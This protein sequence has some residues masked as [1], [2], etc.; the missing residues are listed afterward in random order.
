MFPSPQQVLQQRL[1]EAQAALHRLEI[2]QMSVEVM[3]DGFMTRFQRADISRLMAYIARLEAEIR[4]PGRRLDGAI[5]VIF[6]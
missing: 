3:V 1:F 5:G 2:G 4:R 6:S